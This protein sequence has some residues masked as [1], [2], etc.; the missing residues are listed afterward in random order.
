MSQQQRVPSWLSTSAAYTWRVLVLLIG[1]TVMLAVMTRLYLV[2]LPMLI[3]LILATLGVPPARW[4]E[5]KGF[6]RAAAAGT[7]LAAGIGIIGGTIDALTPAFINQMQQLRPTLLEAFDRLMRWAEE[8]P[9]GWDRAQI[10]T[11][12]SNAVQTIQARSGQLLQ[13]VFTGAAIVAEVL[14]ALV[15]AL[16]LLF[17]FIKDGEQIVAWFIARTPDHHRETVRAAGRRAW[18]ALAGFIREAAQDRHLETERGPDGG[19]QLG[20]VGGAA[21]TGLD[22]RQRPS[23]RS[24]QHQG[25]APPHDEE[26]A[27]QVARASSS[28]RF[29]PT[30][31]PASR[32]SPHVVASTVM[33]RRARSASDRR[34]GSPGTSTGSLAFA[35]GEA[36]T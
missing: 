26:V 15:L 34:S 18:V 7:V 23:V 19:D 9:L 2:T 22:A 29:T 13:Q 30:F 31:S 32:I 21:I 36:F 10:E 16:V 5:T 25:G 11:L 24:V 35:G 28:G 6:P 1:A 4:L 20:N 12:V 17:F 14:V 27:D 3:A 33:P 8:G